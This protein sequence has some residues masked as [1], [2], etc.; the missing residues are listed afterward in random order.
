MIYYIYS[1]KLGDG[2]NIVFATKPSQEM[3]SN[4]YYILYNNYS[5]ERK[6]LKKKN[7]K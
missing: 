3:I 7:K 6:T 4:N 1:G 2:F 5:K